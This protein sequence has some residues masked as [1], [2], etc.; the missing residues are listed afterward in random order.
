MKQAAWV[1]TLHLSLSWLK[2]CVTF[3]G[4]P[5][6]VGLRMPQVQRRHRGDSNPRGESPVDFSFTSLITRT[7]CRVVKSGAPIRLLFS[8][9]LRV[10][11]LYLARLVHFFGGAGIY[12]AKSTASR[13][14]TGD[15]S[16]VNGCRNHKSCAACFP[17]SMRWVCERQG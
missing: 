10:R 11:Y 16:R 12:V 13:D 15:L 4:L 2:P 7:Q 6:A 14:K 17:I 9:V 5:G 3:L 8:Y 1:R